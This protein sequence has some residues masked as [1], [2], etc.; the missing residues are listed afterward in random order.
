M[1]FTVLFL[2]GL[3]ACGGSS[4][5]SELAG[6]P[7]TTSDGGAVTATDCAGVAAQLCKKAVGC[8]TDGRAQ[9]NLGGVASSIDYESEAYCT[10]IFTEQ[11]GPNVPASYHPRVPDP[12]AC[13][14]DLPLS[15]CNAMALVA[16]ASCGAKR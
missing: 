8:G 16:P 10:Q 6:N 9:V 14:R 2:S 7:V 1:R 15:T 3:L 11:C 13:A 5:S 12:A 4:E